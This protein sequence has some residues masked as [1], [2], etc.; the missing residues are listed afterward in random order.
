MGIYEQLSEYVDASFEAVQL[1]IDEQVAAHR[2]QLEKENY[3]KPISALWRAASF[4]T[5][6][7]DHE[8]LQQI[9]V[10]TALEIA[11]HTD[12]MPTLSHGVKSFSEEIAK[13]G[14]AIEHR[15]NDVTTRMKATQPYTQLR[16]GNLPGSTA[17]HLTEDYT[18]GSFK[19]DFYDTRDLRNRS[20]ISSDGL[21][22]YTTRTPFAGNN[23]V[24]KSSVLDIVNAIISPEEAQKPELVATYIGGK[25]HFGSGAP[26]RFLFFG[27]NTIEALAESIVDVYEYRS[28][29]DID[30]GASL[31]VYC[32]SALRHLT[33]TALSGAGINLAENVAG[34][35]EVVGTPIAY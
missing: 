3:L 34:V 21:Y 28:P 35:E 1:N 14:K 29:L 16:H 9:G 13:R 22:Q 12:K 19:K 17:G 7:N 5:P 2:A 25:R 32:P 20:W 6:S 15:L 23:K 31:R 33:T 4:Y 18:I 11:A 30:S 26:D 24:E 27:Q 10:V 8:R